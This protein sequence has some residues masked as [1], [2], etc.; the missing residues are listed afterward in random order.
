MPARHDHHRVQT[1]DG[2]AAYVAGASSA[3]RSASRPTRRRPG[4][5]AAGIGTVPHALIAVVRRQHGARRDE[6]RGV[7]RRRHQHHRAR[8]L[9]ERLGADRARG[10]ARARADASGACGSTRRSQLVDRSLWE[11]MGDFDPTRRQRAPR[12]QGARRARRRRL[13]AREDRR[14]GR[15]HG[16]QDRASSRRRACPVDAYGVGSSLIRGEN[17]FTAD[18]VAHR[19]PPVARRSA[20][21]HASR[22]C[23][24]SSSRDRSSGTSTL[25]STSCFRTGSSHVPGAEADRSRDAARLVDAARGRDRARRLRRR[26]RAHRRGDLGRATTSRTTYPPHCLRGTRGARKI[27]GDRRRRIPFRSRSSSC[28]SAYL[29]GREFLLLKKSFDVF[30]NPNTRPA[31]R[32]ASILTRI[33]VFGVATDVCDDAAIP[34]LPG[35]GARKVRF[36]EDAARGLD[37]ERVAIVT[38]SWR[39][40]GVEFT[41]A[42]GIAP[43]AFRLTRRHSVEMMSQGCRGGSTRLHGHA[44]GLR[45]QLVA[46][47]GPDVLL[48]APL[49]LLAHAAADAARQAGDQ[50][51]VDP[52]TAIE[53]ADIAGV[54]RGEGRAAGDRRV[55][56]RP[57]ALR[58][59]RRASCRRASLLYG[60]PGTGKTLLAQGGRERVGRAASIAQS[61]SAFVE[62]FAGLGA[63]RIRKLFDEARKHAPVDHLHRRARRRRRRAAATASTASRIRRSTSCSSSSTASAGA[64]RSSSWAPRTGSRISTRRC[65]ARAASTARCSSRRPTSQGPRGDPARAHARQAARRRT[66]E[67]ELIARQTAGLTGADLANI[68]NEAAIF[69][70][71]REC[72]DTSARRLR[73]RARARRRRPAAEEGHHATR[74]GGSS[75]TTRRAT[76]SCRI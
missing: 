74:S 68:A 56:A 41:T 10:R 46:T 4:G 17:D 59:A 44:Q 53:W 8:R 24:S 33:V 54:G 57:E 30:T 34:R 43:P 28:R 1:G 36:V 58:G 27:P 39:E 49:H 23:G 52:R 65:C 2:Y 11:E 60:P 14:L 75:P 66:F 32:A 51:R 47:A 22:A 15:L 37:E 21:T 20:G 63:A 6:V 42:E 72:H 38:A 12:A 73:Q 7:G 16:R 48:R 70:G 5:A 61:A 50:S 69:A 55:P 62:M 19:R 45:G 13:R 76:R 64:T 3:R 25:R 9:R 31:A 67:L 40:Q 29:E 35:S 18:I 26:P 71:R